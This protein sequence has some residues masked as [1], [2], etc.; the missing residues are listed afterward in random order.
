LEPIFVPCSGVIIHEFDE[1]VKIVWRFL[2]AGPLR[3][4]AEVEDD[5]MRSGSHEILTNV[6]DHTSVA[7]CADRVSAN[8]RSSELSTC[9]IPASH[10]YGRAF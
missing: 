7:A 4:F 9:S 1:I 10:K 5:G 2:Y 3:R 8:R 6:V